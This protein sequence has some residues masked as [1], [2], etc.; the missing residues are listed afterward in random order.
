L[1]SV[2]RNTFTG[3]IQ[4]R[5]RGSARDHHIGNGIGVALVLIVGS[6]QPSKTDGTTS[7]LHDVSRFVRSR[8]KVRLGR[9]RDGITNRV[10]RST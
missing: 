3:F 10:C 6:S 2:T 7:L 1:D 9:E 4:K 8:M 5:L